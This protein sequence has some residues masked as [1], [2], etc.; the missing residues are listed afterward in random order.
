MNAS[1]AKNKQLSAFEKN[2]IKLVLNKNQD[3]LD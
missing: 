3:K 1:K 2:P